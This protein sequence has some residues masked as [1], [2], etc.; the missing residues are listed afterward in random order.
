MCM[1]L[2]VYWWLFIKI[3]PLCYIWNDRKELYLEFYNFRN[4]TL[5]VCLCLSI[6]FSLPQSQSPLLCLSLTL[7]VYARVFILTKF[8]ISNAEA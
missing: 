5:I 7:S 8:I 1:L 3:C 4:Y 2:I 6:P